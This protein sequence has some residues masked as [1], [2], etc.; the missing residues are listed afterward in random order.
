[1]A[2]PHGL[3]DAPT[4]RTNNSGD[5]QQREPFRPVTATTEI[6]VVGGGRYL[7]EGEARDIKRSILDAARGS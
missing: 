1:M 3:P 4:Q 5:R 7:V 2:Y 6:T